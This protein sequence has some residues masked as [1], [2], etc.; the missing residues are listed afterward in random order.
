LYGKFQ[1]D[2]RLLSWLFLMWDMSS[3]IHKMQCALPQLFSPK[4]LCQKV[5][6]LIEKRGKINV[7]ELNYGRKPGNHRTTLLQANLIQH[8]PKVVTSPIGGGRSHV[9]PTSV[10]TPYLSASGLELDY[11]K[12]AFKFIGH[13]DST[14]LSLY[15]EQKG[16]VHVKMPLTVLVSSLTTAMTCQIA[17]IHKIQLGSH[18][19]KAEQVAYFEFHD[20]VACNLFTSVFERSLLSPWYSVR[21][22]YGLR[23]DC[24]DCSDCPRTPLRLNSEFF[25]QNILPILNSKS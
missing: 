6:K 14:S 8:S 22:P 21:S 12:T 7:V 4:L 15:P 2:D 1:V 13:V 20:C 9:F 23:T 24:T 16:F 18:V 3:V 17:K 5:K 11:S 25:W 10:V 19:K